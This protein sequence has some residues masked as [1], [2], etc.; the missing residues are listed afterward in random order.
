MSYEILDSYFYTPTFP[1]ADPMLHVVANLPTNWVLFVAI[2]SGADRW[3]CY[4]GWVPGKEGEEKAK[5]LIA[6]NGCKVSKEVSVAHFP[7]LDPDK[8]TY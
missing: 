3:K 2:R 6:R 7:S 8:F 5:Q 4:M 1:G